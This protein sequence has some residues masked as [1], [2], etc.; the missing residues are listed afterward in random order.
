MAG[1]EGLSSDDSES[2]EVEAKFGFRHTLKQIKRDPTARFGLYVLAVMLSLTIITTVDTMLSTL[3]FGTFED[4]AIANT[5]PVIE[6]PEEIPAPPFDTWQKPAWYP[7]GTWE[8]PLGTDHQGRDYLSRLV[9]GTRISMMVAIFATLFGAVTGTIVGAVAGYYGGTVDEVLMR[10]MEMI[11]AIPGLILVI[12]FVVF[13]SQNNPDI[14]Y[15]VIGVGLS[16]VP[17][18]ARII[19]SR[20]LSIREMEYIE[21]AKAAGVKDR[22]IIMRHVIPNSFAPVVVYASLYAGVA[23]LIV[24]GLSFLG[25]GAQPPTPD[26]GMM[27]SRA[28]RTQM[29]INP[30]ASVWPGIAIIVTVLGF[31]LLGDGL[32]DALDPRIEN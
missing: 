24:S 20:V 10:I 22:H 13:V 17:V 16:T 7:D 32:Q 9:Y 19:R 21:A 31:N 15:A 26:W 25:Y 11:Y 4:F 28:H 2:S 6:N 5:M 12:V 1:T 3:T 23:I 18:F 29:H 30:L 14:Q 27:I 8:H